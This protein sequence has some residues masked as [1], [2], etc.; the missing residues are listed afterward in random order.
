MC[1][2]GQSSVSRPVWAKAPTP[3][4]LCTNTWERCDMTSPANSAAQIE[5]IIRTLKTN[6]TF[7]DL[8]P[9]DLAWL[10]ERMEDLRVAAGEVLGRRGDPISHLNVIIEGEIQVEFAEEPGTPRFI[11]RQGQITGALPFSRLKNY[12]GTTRA[13]LPL[14]VLRL[15]MQYFPEL[16]Q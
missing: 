15:H 12:M 3:Y 11:A 8:S 4:S 9:E 1:A 6:A 13:A 7:A 16:I 14:H 5:S 2:A 10:A